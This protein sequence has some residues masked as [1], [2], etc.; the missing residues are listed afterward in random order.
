MTSHAQ[1]IASL[2]NR[3]YGAFDKSLI[4]HLVSSNRDE[5]EKIGHG[6]HFE[7]FLVKRT[8]EPLVVKIADL[9]SFAPQSPNRRKL[10]QAI[11]EVGRRSIALWPPMEVF[12]CG[13]EM[14]IVQPYASQKLREAKESWQ[15]ISD[16]IDELNR[17]LAQA[18]YKI[19]DIQQGGCL[20]GIPFV[21]DVSD[22]KKT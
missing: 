7:V 2:K 13:D 9:E 18:G 19:E 4:E 11:S 6:S 20:D 12:E 15:P 1:D 17:A 3:F 16:H 10:V 14:V 8:S 21:Y 5:L 22:L